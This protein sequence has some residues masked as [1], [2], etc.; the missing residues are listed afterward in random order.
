MI[1]HDVVRTELSKLEDESGRLTPQIVLDAAKRESHPLHEYFEW[2]DSIAAQAWRVEQAR[3]LIRSVKLVVTTDRIE[4]STV[5]YVRDPR[6]P[7]EDQGYVGIPNAQS[8]HDLAQQIIRQEF[9]R[10]DAA[11]GRAEDV[12]K[13]L[14]ME[15]VIVRARKRLTKSVEEFEHGMSSAR[16]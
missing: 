9:A 10:A 4:F 16:T 5:H 14:G 12:A 3:G 8:D 1:A 2:D 6:V 11:L 15:K 13:A 7:M